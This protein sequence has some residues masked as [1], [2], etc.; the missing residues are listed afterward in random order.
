[1][2]IQ[3][4][5]LRGYVD[6]ADAWGADIIARIPEAEIEDLCPNSGGLRQAGDLYAEWPKNY[7]WDQGVDLI[8]DGPR[9][10]TQFADDL[11]PWLE[12]EGWVR[13]HDREFPPGKESFTRASSRGAYTLA[14]EI[15]TVAPPRAQTIN[16]SIVRPTTDPNRD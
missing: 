16:F 12:E 8:P 10:P 13:D 5:Q 2:G 6:Q 15:Y 9:T 4:S 3:E 7:F 1:M 14:V 11:E